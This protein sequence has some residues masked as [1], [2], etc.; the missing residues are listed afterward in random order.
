MQKT[1]NEEPSFHKF[2]E[3]FNGE[4]YEYTTKELTEMAKKHIGC[5]WTAIQLRNRFKNI[6]PQVDLAKKVKRE[7][8]FKEKTLAYLACIYFLELSNPN[9]TIEKACEKALSIIKRQKELDDSDNKVGNDEEEETQTH[10]S[11]A[12]SGDKE[13]TERDM[14]KGKEIELAE[15]IASDFLDQDIRVPQEPLVASEVADEL[16][17]QGFDISSGEI[18][19]RVRW[20]KELDFLILDKA[21]QETGELNLYSPTIIPILVLVK[22]FENRGESPQEACNRVI[23]LLKKE[24]VNL[25]DKEEVDER[26]REKGSEDS[27]FSE[28]KSKMKSLF[29]KGTSDM[30]EE[31][32]LQESSPTPVKAEEDRN[33]IPQERTK[34]LEKERSSG[35]EKIIDINKIREEYGLQL[36]KQF[37]LMAFTDS[38]VDQKWIPNSNEIY[39]KFGRKTLNE[40]LRDF[41]FEQGYEAKQIEVHIEN[42]GKDRLGKIGRKIGLQQHIL[43]GKDQMKEANSVLSQ[44]I[45]AIVAV[46]KF[47]QSW[48]EARKWIE[49]FLLTEVSE[50]G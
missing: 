50:D 8:R 5:S 1:K 7:Y 49:N 12:R 20:L 14:I 29:S 39:A 38:S 2:R 28:M 43:V 37:I 24:R 9:Y 27:F 48:V 10:L 42:W 15:S 31:E 41:Y 40:V 11:K 26:R 45:L 35:E 21:K 6:E 34:M 33:R 36:E 16:Q 44:V 13:T 3:K 23:K 17:D 4:E 46:I 19:Y 32:M 25:S 47:H 22:K 30:E 18:S